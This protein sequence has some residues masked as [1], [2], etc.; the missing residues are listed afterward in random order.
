MLPNDPVPNDRIEQVL[1][2]VSG[3]GFRAKNIVL[4]NNGIENRHYALDPR[5]GKSTHTNARITAEAV[6]GLVRESGIAPQRIEGLAC[7]TS[8][9]DHL[10]PPHAAMVQ[11][12]LGWPLMETVST[13][14]VCCSGVAAWKHAYLAVRSGTARNY[15]AAGSERVSPLLRAERFE[16]TA[17]KD[18]D[19][20]A[21][22]RL[23]HAAFSRDFLR[24]MLSDGAGAFLLEDQPRSGRSCL[25]IEWMDIL[26]RAG[27]LPPCMMLGGIPNAPGRPVSWMDAP[28]EHCIRDGYFQITQD[29]RLLEKHIVSCVIGKAFDRIVRKR[30]IRPEDIHWFLPHYS[31]EYFREKL[32]EGLN[33][34][35]FLI[36]Q[37]NWFTNLRQK[38]NT[39]AASIFV[40]L[41]ELFR[42]GKIAAGERILCMIPESSRFSVAYVLLSAC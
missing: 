21:P 20:N 30:K 2:R 12:E 39:G 24:W 38:G 25:K 40:M 8:T 32:F 4:K 26:S 1:G 18:P 19:G 22:E 36:P 7:G 10:F 23:P 35:G 37:K 28:P 6:Q 17:N 14:G 42:S 34:A 16:K 41:D 15:V 13:S 29:I 27:Q 5:T 9:P 31:S 11:G 3:R 33:M